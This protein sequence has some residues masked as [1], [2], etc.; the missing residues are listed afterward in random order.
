[1][2]SYEYVLDL[3]YNFHVNQTI[4]YSSQIGI[5]MSMLLIKQKHVLHIAYEMRFE[6][7]TYW[8]NLLFAP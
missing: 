1:M 8:L 3:F 4:F 6:D 5:H 7:K 2:A